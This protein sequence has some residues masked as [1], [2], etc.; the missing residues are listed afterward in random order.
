MRRSFIVV[1]TGCVLLGVAIAELGARGGKRSGPVPSA[2]EVAAIRAAMARVKPFFDVKG[3][4]QAGDWLESHKEAGQTFDQYIAGDP[5]RPSR[6]RTTIYIQPIGSFSKT[7]RK[8]LDATAD[9]LGRFYNVPVKTLEPLALDVIPADARRINANT[10]AE[11]LLT[12]YIL[13]K[14]LPNRRPDDAV[15]R[16]WR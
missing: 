8:L 12:T 13:E 6:T 7:E 3:K 1:I 16:C 5:N 9:L 11:Q 10:K 15:A 4:S 14:L 2:E